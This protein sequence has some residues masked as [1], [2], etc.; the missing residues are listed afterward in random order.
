MAITI[1]RKLCLPA[2]IYLILAVVQIISSLLYMSP[3][4]MATVVSIVMVLIWTWLLNYICDAGF[5]IVSW[6]LVL[7]PI[8]LVLILLFFFR[9]IYMGLTESEKKEVIQAIKEGVKEGQKK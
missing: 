2:L 9:E 7:A 6:I 3:T 5:T 4:F 1:P 8:F